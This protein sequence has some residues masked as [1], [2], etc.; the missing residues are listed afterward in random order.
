MTRL[1]FVVAAIILSSTLA[2]S[3]YDWGRGLGRFH[4]LKECSYVWFFPH[5]ELDAVGCQRRGYRRRKGA[6]RY[7][8][9]KTNW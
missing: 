5:G 7:R 6:G 1:A 4:K 8:A 3:D 9:V 2:V